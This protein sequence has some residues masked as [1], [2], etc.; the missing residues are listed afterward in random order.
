MKKI[1]N[2]VHSSSCIE[3][4][5]LIGKNTKIWH[6]SHISENVKIGNECTLGQNTFVGKNVKIRNNVKI[7]NNVSVFE[8]VELHNNVFCG[9]S[10]VFTN[11]LN[12]RSL[13]NQK[14]CI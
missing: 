6:F 12:P 13:I 8:G 10:V 2:F 1:T 4:N 7:Q 3:K 14:N 9:P 11:I 5:V